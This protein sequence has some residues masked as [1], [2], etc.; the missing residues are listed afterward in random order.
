MRTAA[1][2]IDNRK[3]ER[4]QNIIDAHMSFLP[5][6]DLIHFDKLKIKHF[7]DYNNIL[8]SNNFWRQLHYDKIL[9]FQHD[10]M[11][12]RTGIEEFLDY[13]YVGAPW[14]A[15]APWARKDRAGGNG[16]ISIRDVAQSEYLTRT[17][18]FKL[19]N[20][21][22]WFTHN[23]PGV[24]PYEGCSRFSV[25]TEFK[26][27][28]FAYHAIDKHLTRFECDKIVKQYG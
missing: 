22:V 19:G 27:G 5:N 6:W 21:D 13:N 12:L 18:Q 16:G 28:T 1:V 8:T 15:S 9:I 11:I 14:F 23:L 2:I 20:E 4:L 10:S 25:E 3:S 17:K 7:Q 24:A 26:L